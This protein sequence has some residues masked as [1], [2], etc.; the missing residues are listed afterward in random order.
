MLYFANPAGKTGSRGKAR[1][2][3]A[4]LAGTIG[5]IDTPRQGNYRHPAIPVWCADNGCFSEAFDEAQ[6][7][8]FLEAN[9]HAVSSCAFATA[10]D[11]VGDHEATVKRSTPWLRQIRALGYKVA[12]V[13]Q[14]GWDAST[15]PW[16]DIDVIFI[17]GDDDFKIGPA[18]LR[19]D[20]TPRGEVPSLQAV[21]DAR[22]HGKAVHYGR[23]N[24]RKRF[25]FASR[26]AQADSADG[27]FLT[28]GNT[29]EGQN[30]DRLLGWIAELP[31]A[32]PTEA[33][34]IAKAAANAGWMPAE[35]G[36]AQGFVRGDEVLSVI[37]TPAGRALH[38]VYAVY[39]RPGIDAVHREAVAV[40]A[41]TFA[42]AVLS[43]L[44]V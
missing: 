2:D 3:A 15:V 8:A 5:F 34:R 40:D 37:F 28:F 31:A 44:V 4:M 7:W 22:A 39:D 18:G 33:E 24:S 20:G 14:N 36:H 38:A 26:I 17:G 21:A 6:W 32:G 1:V 41:A 13:A 29:T 23:V 9:A 25:R 42:L 12:F 35:A 43:D 27:T 11:V 10:P 30:L 16:D 19:M